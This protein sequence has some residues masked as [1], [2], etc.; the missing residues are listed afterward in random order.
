[1][2]TIF[3]LISIAAVYDSSFA[4]SDEQEA[5]AVELELYRY[6][7]REKLEQSQ[8]PA[9]PGPATS[10]QWHSDI[11]E[12]QGALV[13]LTAPW[14]GEPCK[15]FKDMIATNQEA[16]NAMNEHYCVERG[17]GFAKKYGVGAFPSL[18]LLDENHKKVGAVVAPLEPRALVELLARPEEE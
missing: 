14:C 13:L 4:L 6:R 12:G 2:T 5:V 3:L 9:A 11:H 8:A 18:L 7:Q 1:M 16:I 15:K 17:E 10:V